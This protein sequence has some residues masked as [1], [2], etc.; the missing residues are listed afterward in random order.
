MSTKKIDLPM[1]RLFYKASTIMRDVI[2]RCGVDH[3]K[4]LDDAEGMKSVKAWARGEIGVDE[5][6]ERMADR[7]ANNPDLKSLPTTAGRERMEEK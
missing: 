3:W 2:V 4:L 1:E 5:F 7:L 6:R